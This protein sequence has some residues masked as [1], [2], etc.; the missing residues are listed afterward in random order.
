MSTE[1]GLINYPIIAVGRT[2]TVVEL[3]TA[4]RINVINGNCYRQDGR[5]CQGCPSPV[6][7]ARHCSLFLL[8]STLTI[9]AKPVTWHD[10]AFV[11]A[12]NY[13]RFSGYLGLIG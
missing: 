9:L 7:I 8:C 2:K 10:Y 4:R 3:C 13:F 1:W 11:L 12:Y 5:C 6:D